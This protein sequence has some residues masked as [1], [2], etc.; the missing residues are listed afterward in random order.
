MLHGVIRN[1][2]SLALSQEHRLGHVFSAT[3]RE[4]CIS[5]THPLIDG[6]HTCYPQSLLDTVV[7][8]LTLF[9]LWKRNLA[10]TVAAEVC[11][12]NLSQFVEDAIVA[13]EEVEHPAQ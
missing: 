13:G 1:Q 5:D 8:I 11:N 10:R 2:D 12:D 4:G 9:E 7:E 3:I 6:H